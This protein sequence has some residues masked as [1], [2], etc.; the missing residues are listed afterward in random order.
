MLLVER[1]CHWCAVFKV[2][3]AVSSAAFAAAH[4]N[5]AEAL[6]LFVLGLMLGTTAIAAEGNLVAPTIAHALYNGALFAAIAAQT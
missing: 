3:V 4:L 1:E 5:P 2:Q 6:P